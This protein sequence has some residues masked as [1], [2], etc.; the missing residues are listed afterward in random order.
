MEIRRDI[1]YCY[2]SISSYVSAIYMCVKNLDYFRIIFK[3][4]RNLTLKKADKHQANL[5]YKTNETRR[6]NYLRHI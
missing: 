6:K 4:E 5:Q 3:C 1:V 2:L